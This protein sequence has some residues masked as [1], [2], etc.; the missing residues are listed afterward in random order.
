MM[1]PKNSRNFCIM[2]GQRKWTSA[3][4]N[5]GF[6]LCAQRII[7]CCSPLT[8]FRRDMSFLTPR[9]LRASS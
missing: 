6:S 2:N 9:T 8:I 5:F 1:L 7:M 3:M 4:S